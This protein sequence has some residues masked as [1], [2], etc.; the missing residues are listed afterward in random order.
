V[1]ALQNVRLLIDHGNRTIEIPLRGSL[2]VQTQNINPRQEPADH[3]QRSD[4]SVADQQGA[5]DKEYLN[6]MRG[7]LMTV[8]T[9]FISMAFQAAIQPPDWVPHNLFQIVL[10]NRKLSFHFEGAV[11]ARLYMLANMF[12]FGIALT[13]L[14][15]LLTMKKPPPTRAVKVATQT[16]AALAV[17]VALSFAFGAAANNRGVLAFIFII[18]LVCYIVGTDGMTDE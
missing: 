18:F 15:M 16:M 3:S 12:T 4:T 6:Q 13:L 2:I 8:A 11:M 14:V 1:F 10:H 9:L 7:W 5:D 17:T